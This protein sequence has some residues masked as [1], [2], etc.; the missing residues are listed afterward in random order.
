MNRGRTPARGTRRGAAAAG[1][2]APAA[3][4]ESSAGP[5]TAPAASTAASG[6]TTPAIRSASSARGGAVA[7]ATRG[8]TVGRFRPKNIR[9]DEAEREELARQEEQKARER[10]ADERRARGRSRF[11]SKRS[12]GDAMGRGGFGRIISGAS[13]PF[14]SGVAG[15][16]GGGGWFGG[17]GGGGNFGGGGFGRGF[18]SESKPGFAQ[19]DGSRFREARINA[20]KLHVH[21]PEEELDSEDEAMMNVLSTRAPSVLPMG[22]YRKEH[23]EEGVVVAT[24]AELE[25][26]ENAQNAPAATSEEESLW[27]DDDAGAGEAQTADQGE[28]GTWTESKPTIKK[29]PGDDSIDMD[30]E[31]QPTE[32][33]KPSEEAPAA[34]PKSKKATAQELEDKFV[35]LDLALLRSELGSIEITEGEGEDGKKAAP[36]N[37]DGRLYLFRFPPIMPPLKQVTQPK[38]VSKVKPEPTEANVLEST[39]AAA[40]GNP[41]DLTLED[42][43]SSGLNNGADDPENKHGFMPSLMTQ[44]GMIGQLKVHKSGRT[45]LDWGGLL[46]DMGSSPDP[47][48]LTTAVIVEE[49]DEK[50]RPGVVGGESFGM[51]KIMGRFGLAPFWDE[52]EDWEVSPED[53]KIT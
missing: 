15:S 33:K 29:E 26:A 18:K 22:I 45:T 20:D 9:R 21:T 32:E 17:G 23:K 7:R 12:R 42:L 47:G 53:L 46:L 24:T 4:G 8:A 14:S 52:E 5:S 27:V 36:S 39:P 19:A 40:D 30:I 16:S 48:F 35:D 43:V 38:P 34:K 31:V 13:G 51:G 10:E 44:G 41:V 49:N 11:R 6:S 50:P 3:T 25:A 37:K 1:Q 2:R 28:E